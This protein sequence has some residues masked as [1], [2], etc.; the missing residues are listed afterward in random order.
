MDTVQCFRR[1]PSSCQELPH[2]KKSPSLLLTYNSVY[3]TG[4]KSLSWGGLAQKV[5]HWKV[6][7]QETQRG[8]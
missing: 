8:I 6:K 5:Y 1:K 2:A 3:I 7:N 4:I